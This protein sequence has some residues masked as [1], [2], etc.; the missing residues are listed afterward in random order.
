MENE[1][2]Q[3]RIPKRKL[4][5]GEMISCI[6]MGTF[7]NDGFSAEQVSS[8]VAGAIRAGYRL[9]DGA[10][11]YKNENLIG[12]VFKQAFDEGVVRR[13]EM[14]ISS[15]VW[16][17]MQK[18]GDV[19]VALAT[20]LRDL[21]LDYLDLYFVHWPFRNAHEPGCAGGA[22]NPN[23][24]P[25]NVDEYM[26][27]WRQMERLV[28]MGLVRNI[29][30]SNMT[31]P[32]L[33]AVLPY[34]R[35]KPVALEIE[36]HPCFQQPELYNYCI[37]RKIM[38][39]GYAP[40]G[41]PTRPERDMNSSDIADIKEPRIVKIAHDHGV[42]PAIVCLKW[43]VQRGQIPIPFSIYENEYV[44]N[45]HCATEDPLSDEEMVTLEKIDKN[46]RLM[47]GQVFLWK[48]AKG[49]EDLWDINGEITK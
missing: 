26:E 28:D 18:Q 46:C 9:F 34:C 27:T 47:K 42:H 12:K 41:S 10:A 39:I 22:R 30:M 14:F 25:F 5:T 6:G 49:W 17:D 3:D 44:S 33:N 48:N 19:L 2:D 45:L 35:I 23:A 43:A 38:P 36:L 40:I 7:G 31:I 16:N 13:D 37:K 1:I 24:N 32:K 21:K 15:K 11:A 8:A 4:Y 29:G 20:T